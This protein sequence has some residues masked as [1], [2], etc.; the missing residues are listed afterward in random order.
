MDTPEKRENRRRTS[1][2][3]RF[4]GG[5]LT[6]LSL[7]T[8]GMAALVLTILGV[9]SLI[10]GFVLALGL[11]GLVVFKSKVRGTFAIILALCAGVFL[12]RTAL[13][14]SHQRDWQPPLENLAR[15]VIEDDTVVLHGVRNFS[16]KSETDYQPA[17]ETRRYHLSNLRSV[18]LL[19]EPF[20]YSSLMAHTMMSFDFGEDG[21]LVLSIEARKE[22]GEE[23][24]AI[25][26]GLNQFE[27]I[28]LFLDEKDA[29]GQR[30]HRGHELY[31]FPIRAEPLH[32][33]AFFLSLCSSTD[34]LLRKPRFYHI[35]RHNCTTTWLEHADLISNEPVGFRLESILNGLIVELLH[36]RGLIDTDLSYDEARQAFRI[37]PQILDALSD[38]DFS[39]AIRKGRP[40]SA[41]DDPQAAS[42]NS[43][44]IPDAR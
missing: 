7:I 42:A 16:W 32:L 31:A 20:A 12:W 10:P 19:F 36:K 3:R 34:N 15:P 18:D 1:P 35:I 33:R 43:T 21:R 37:D 13:Q 30:A 26:G 6:V 38:Q 9:G 40:S 4:L 2:A 24:D 39:A 27:L 28:Y 44:S 5:L 17:W 29:L 41:A 25:L 14:P 11:V 23:Y 22:V 8:W